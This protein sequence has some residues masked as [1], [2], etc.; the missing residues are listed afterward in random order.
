LKIDTRLNSDEEILAVG[1]HNEGNFVH[2][3][4][5]TTL[6]VVLKQ[7]DTV[8]DFIGYLSEKET[9]VG[10][11]PFVIHG[12]ENLLTNYLQNR[13]ASFRH[14]ISIPQNSDSELTEIHDG[15]W[16]K[17]VASDQFRHSVKENQIS[18]NIDLLIEHFTRAFFGGQLAMG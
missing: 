6:D 1:C 10:T 2:I 15:E 9:V 13:D 3:L 7:L 12:E 16:D 17:Y 14:T 11:N 4:D 8:S 18:Y 5:D